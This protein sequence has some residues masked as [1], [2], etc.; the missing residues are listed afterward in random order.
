MRG[1]PLLLL[2]ITLFNC[3]RAQ[4]SSSTVMDTTSAIGPNMIRIIGKVI[5]ASPERATLKVTKVLGS[6]Q[7]IINMPGEGQE[8][9]VSVTDKSKKLKRG[10]TIAAELTEKMGADASQSFYIILQY[11]PSH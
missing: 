6:G 4:V 9:P 2:F 5:S 3:S 10:E 7:G 11:Q 8:I 1:L